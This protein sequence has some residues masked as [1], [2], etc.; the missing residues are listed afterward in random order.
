MPLIHIVAVFWKPWMIKLT[1]KELSDK[2]SLTKLWQKIQIMK[3]GD[4]IFFRRTALINN[5]SIILQWLLM[6]L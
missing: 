2:Q 6:T 1:Q 5:I 3:N 4:T